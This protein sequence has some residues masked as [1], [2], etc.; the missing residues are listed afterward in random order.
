MAFKIALDRET[1]TKGPDVNEVIL[2]QLRANFEAGHTC[3]RNFEEFVIK[4]GLFPKDRLEDLASLRDKRLIDK[5]LFWARLAMQC[6]TVDELR[7]EMRLSEE[8]LME[9]PIPLDVYDLNRVKNVLVCAYKRRM[10][11][12]REERESD[13]LENT[14]SRARGCLI[15]GQTSPNI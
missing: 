13:G 14:R 8:R 5:V 9:F 15:S 6:K 3:Y 4:Q 2:E 12:L 10:G 1:E 7:N 11:E